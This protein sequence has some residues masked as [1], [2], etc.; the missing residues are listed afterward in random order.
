MR[1]CRI[2][3]KVLGS[4]NNP[5]CKYTCLLALQLLVLG[6]GFNLD[7]KFRTR[8]QDFYTRC[9]TGDDS[10]KYNSELYR[11]LLVENQKQTWADIEQVIKQFAIDSI[12]MEINIEEEKAF[13]DYL[14]RE[15]GFY[16]HGEEGEGCPESG[17]SRGRYF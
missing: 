12:N 13:F 11:R 17:L 4:I 3:S 6:N 16:M 10:L 14:V 15:L 8:Y 7:M 2:Q 1:E 9:L 5:N